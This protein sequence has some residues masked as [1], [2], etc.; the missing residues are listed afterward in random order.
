[1]DAAKRT[2]KK[3][4]YLLLDTKGLTAK[5][6]EKKA[7]AANSFA[8]L[9]YLVELHEFIPESAGR[10]LRVKLMEVFGAA[11]DDVAA[12]RIES[13]SEW[14]PIFF[15]KARAPFFRDRSGERCEAMRRRPTAR[16][17]PGCRRL[18]GSPCMMP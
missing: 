6:L 12:L 2:V 10:T 15:E 18:R 16:G 13:L 4:G 5:G 3:F 17:Q 14:S 1:M 11:N 8:K 9:L 7:M